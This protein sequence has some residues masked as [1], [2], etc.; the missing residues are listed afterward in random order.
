MSKKTFSIFKAVKEAYKF[1]GREKSY[2]FKMGTYPVVMN[3]IMSL[4]VQF[5]ITEP[6]I[7]EDYLWNLPATLTFGWFTFVVIRLALL[8]ERMDNLPTD[9]NYISNRNLLLKITATI[10][11]LFNMVTIAITGSLFAITQSGLWGKNMAVTFL[12][13]ILIGA[14]FWSIRFLAFPILAAVNYPFKKFLNIVKGPLFSLQ[15]LAMGML[16]LIPL[17]FIF[18]VMVSNIIIRPE[19][20]VEGF[21]LSMQQKILLII[22]SAPLSLLMNLLLNVSA[23]FALKEILG[24]K[25]NR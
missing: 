10:Y 15:F 25:E 20:M 22:F 7:I 9:K 24:S 14:M 21:K 8:G 16:C 12:G 17:L 13:L 11:I 6:S 23:I 19:A 4:F 2:L 18:Q 3:I 5:S 1:V